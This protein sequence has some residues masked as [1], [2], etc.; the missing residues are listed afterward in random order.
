MDRNKESEEFLIKTAL[1]FLKSDGWRR[2]FDSEHFFAK[3]HN[4]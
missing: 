4:L 1:R 3:C 2:V